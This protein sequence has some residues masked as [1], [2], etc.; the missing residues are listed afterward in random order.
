MLAAEPLKEVKYLVSVTS[1]VP[2]CYN[3][4]IPMLN[5]CNSGFSSS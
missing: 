3:I 2:S 1:S 5:L 4:L